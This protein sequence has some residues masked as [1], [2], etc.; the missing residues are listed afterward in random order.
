MDIAKNQTGRDSFLQ[1]LQLCH[2]FQASLLL[3]AGVAICKQTSVTLPFGLDDSPSTVSVPITPIPGRAKTAPTRSSTRTPRGSLPVFQ[4]EKTIKVD[5]L[6]LTTPLCDD[7]N[8]TPNK[9]YMPPSPLVNSFLSPV[10]PKP[11]VTPKPNYKL[12]VTPKTV[13]KNPNNYNK[14][15]AAIQASVLPTPTKMHST[16]KVPSSPKLSFASPLWNPKASKKEMK[17]LQSLIDSGETKLVLSQALINRVVVP[18]KD[19]IHSKLES[20]ESCSS[21]LSTLAKKYRASA[22]ATS[23]VLRVKE[24]TQCTD[25]LLTKINV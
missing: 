12:Q 23:E 19:Q 14:I 25:Q 7:E 8:K 10:T 4:L 15:L 18:T 22:Y 6:Q 20:L 9:A 17:I 21:E 24:I 1:F 16:R 2:Q 5:Q 13:E 3:E 11:S